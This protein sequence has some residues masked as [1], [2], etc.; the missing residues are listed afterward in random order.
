MKA[1]EHVII[2][3]LKLGET[4]QLWKALEDDGFYTISNIA[5][6]TDSEINAL[7]YDDVDTSGDVDKTAN[8]IEAA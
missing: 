8:T 2:N 4:S 3:V 7:Q 5:T 1:F 6:L